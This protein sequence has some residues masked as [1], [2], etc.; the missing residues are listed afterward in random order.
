M[1]VFP[2]TS[3]GITQAVTDAASTAVKI[4]G[5]GYMV[6][7][8]NEG[9]NVAFIAAGS[10]TV[11]ATVPAATEAQTCMAVLA[12]SDVIFQRDPN[13]DYYISAICRTGKTTT[14]TISCSNGV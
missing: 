14:L 13:K 12:G 6:R 7:I 1:S 4:P 10:S 8:C 11:A 5:S 3:P 2:I 9:S